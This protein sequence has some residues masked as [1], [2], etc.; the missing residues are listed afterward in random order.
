MTSSSPQPVVAAEKLEKVFRD[1]WRR[2]RVKAV[3][4][5]SFEIRS[6]EVFGLLGPNGSGK[7]TTIKMILGLLFPTRGSLRVLGQSPRDI[8][9]KARIGYLPEES[10]LYPHLTAAETLDFY[11]RL[12][13]LAAGERRERARQLLDMVGLQHA[14]NRL[15]GEFSKGMMRRIG[16]AQALINDPDLVILDEPTSGLDPIGCRQVKDLLLTLAKRGKTVIL[17]SHLLA[18]VEDVCDRI[19]ILFNGRLQALGSIRDL[20][21]V[22]GTTRITLPDTLTPDQTARVLASLRSELS[23]EPAIDHPRRDLEQFFLE[24][25]QRARKEAPPEAATGAAPDGNVAEY[26]QKPTPAGPAV[27][28]DDLLKHLVVEE[29]NDS[30]PKP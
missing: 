17:S 19:A 28:P 10:H 2:P 26:L 20:L 13:D 18:D 3:Q 25:V 11:G 8:K 14:R 30:Q 27:N 5:L 23:D 15:V 21:E 16:I 22:R 6:G 4:D 24:V 29:P 9:I 7:S 12:F 1:F